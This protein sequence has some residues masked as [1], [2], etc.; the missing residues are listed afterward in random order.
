MYTNPPT[1]SITL[2]G[3]QLLA[4]QNLET[5]KDGSHHSYSRQYWELQLPQWDKKN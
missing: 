1:L 5:G 2:S 4:T 3:K